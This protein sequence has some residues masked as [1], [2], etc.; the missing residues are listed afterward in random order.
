[1]TNTINIQTLTNT[2][3]IKLNHKVINFYV[4]TLAKYYPLN[5]NIGIDKVYTSIQD[6]LYNSL[7]YP[8]K[9]ELYGEGYL[10]DKHLND[11]NE[12]FETIILN[13]H[14]FDYGFTN[15]DSLLRLLTNQLNKLFIRIKKNRMKK[16]I[17]TEIENNNNFILDGKYLK[18]YTHLDNAHIAQMII[19]KPFTQLLSYFYFYEDTSIDYNS[20]TLNS[21]VLDIHN[22]ITSKPFYDRLLNAINTELNSVR[23][24]NL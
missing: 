19:D 20:D 14:Y 12:I 22:L 16:T 23:S 10:K 1:M 3:D 21:I 8:I 5:G 17:L 2:V 15:A 13:G 6:E 7:Y 11:F 24:N 4:I 18:Y 9:N